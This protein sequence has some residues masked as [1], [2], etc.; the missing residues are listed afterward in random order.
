MP[1]SLGFKNAKRIAE[2]FVTN[3]YPGGYREDRGYNWF[4]GS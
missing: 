1:S 4:S 2:V 3:G